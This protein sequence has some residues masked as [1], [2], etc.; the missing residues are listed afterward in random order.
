[1]SARLDKIRA[2]REKARVK[3][4]EW[5]AK[6]NELDKKYQE[7]EKTEISDMVHAARLTVDQLAELLRT[8]VPSLLQ[9]PVKEEETEVQDAEEE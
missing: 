5:D 4:D 1:M 3:R 2:D 7:E 8:A 9:R 6:Y